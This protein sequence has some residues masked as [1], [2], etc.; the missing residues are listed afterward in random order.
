MQTAR[1]EALFQQAQSF[2]VGGVN[3]PV[4]AFGAVGGTPRFIAGGEGA[5]VIDAD[6]NHYIDYVLSWGP[7]IVGHA[8][9][10]VREALAE[11]I[12]RGTSYG[13]PNE[14]EIQLAARIQ[15]HFPS[16]ER[17]R[18]V[19]SGAEATLGA[20][21]LARAFTR[22][23]KVV[24]FDGCYHGAVDALLVR[25][26]S[27]VATLGLPDS[28]G[29]P[30]AV[31]ADTL[32]LPYND[33]EAAQRL[34]AA[35]GEAIAAIIVEPVTNNM[36]VILPQTGFLEG[37]RNLADAYG[38]LLIFDEV[39][40]GFRVSLGGAQG[41]FGIRPDLTTLGK[42]VGGGLPVGAFGGRADILELLAPQGPVYQAGTLSGNPLAMV[43]G[44]A[45]IA[46]LEQ[47]GT[48]EYLETMAERLQQAIEAAAQHAD[49]PVV[50]HRAGTMT[51][52][53]FAENDPQNFE[54]AKATHVEWYPTFF[55]AL[56]DAGIYLPPSP[57][58]TLF[59]STA[60]TQALLEQTAEALSNAMQHVHALMA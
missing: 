58:E 26:G 20:L 49:L 47:P 15:R 33:L 4:R 40:T 35:Q 30:E 59:V 14:A 39:A 44:N 18:M 42:V 3:S 52:L 1:S 37:L 34:F 50:V 8:H 53:F 36:G 29:V 2:F 13:A 27:G 54:Q 16:M 17:M 9:P 21:R 7:L 6:G 60:H 41:F 31:T 48:W 5:E 45:T 11:Q 12:E 22:R 10:R 51:G 23:N 32:V 25:A 55:H 19:N 28:P 24:K 38:A 46:L 57:F 56:L 43:A